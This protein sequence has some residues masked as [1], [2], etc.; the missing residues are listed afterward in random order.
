MEF[1]GIS[2]NVTNT[3][4]WGWLIQWGENEVG[5]LLPKDTLFHILQC[6]NWGLKHLRQSF[7]NELYLYIRTSNRDGNGDIPWDIVGTTSLG[8]E[9]RQPYLSHGKKPHSPRKPH[10]AH[11][12]RSC[13]PQILQKTMV[14]FCDFW[15]GTPPRVRITINH[16]YPLVNVNKKLWKITMLL[17]GKSTISMAIFNSYVNLPEGKSH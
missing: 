1:D 9:N 17:M 2:W 14:Y 13:Q 10:P 8:F 5:I 6:C 16:R 11:F 3:I 15:G 12:C 4:F 7:N